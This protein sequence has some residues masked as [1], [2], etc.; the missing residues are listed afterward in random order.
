MPGS[1]QNR[2]AG[3]GKPDRGTARR[4]R[5]PGK[6]NE[7]LFSGGFSVSVD[8]ARTECYLYKRITK[9]LSKGEGYERV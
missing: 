6:N 5:E 4:Q 9:F 3:R 7:A 8:F 2:K 1:G